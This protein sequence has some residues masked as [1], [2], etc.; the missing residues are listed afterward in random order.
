M[1]MPT[2]ARASAGASLTPSPTIAT[3][4]PRPCSSATVRSLSSGS[5]SANTSSTPSC[6]PDGVGD[7]PG[8]AGDHDD[9]VDAEA[10]ELGDGL[11][12]LG[13]DLVLEGERADD[14]RR[15]RTR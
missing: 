8:V 5:T 7:G 4:R 13:P 9:V 14:R 11:G 2:S 3:V 1:A 6:S 10:V 12:R 15:S